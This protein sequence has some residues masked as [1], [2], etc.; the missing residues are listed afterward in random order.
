M[1][2]QANGL[3]RLDKESLPSNKQQS[4]LKHLLIYTS[5]LKPG[6]RYSD[7]TSVISA[8][9][10]DQEVKLLG[11]KPDALKYFMDG[12]SSSTG[13]SEEKSVS[14][15]KA[16]FKI[17]INDEEKKVRDQSQTTLYHTG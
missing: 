2:K 10:H 3:F 1:T 16:T 9:L 11:N 4:K 12:K 14:Q 8:N 17:E 13:K 7:E 15:V 5:V 6:E